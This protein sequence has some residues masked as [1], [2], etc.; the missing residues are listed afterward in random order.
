MNIEI[1]DIILAIVIIGVLYWYFN[2]RGMTKC[3]TFNANCDGVKCVKQKL[4]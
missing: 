1:Q 2:V 4:N 3:I